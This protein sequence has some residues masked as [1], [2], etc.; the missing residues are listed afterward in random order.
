MPLHAGAASTDITPPLGSSLAGHFNDRRAEEVH[1][2]LRAKALVL[3]SGGTSLAIAILDL[4]CCPREILDRAKEGIAERCGIPPSHVLIACTHTHTGPATTGLL[5][6]EPV[7]GYEAFLIPRIVEAVTRAQREMRP[8]RVGW[9]LGHEPALVFNRR[10]QM[11]DG[12]VRTN[13]G[14]LNPEIVAPVGP[15]DPEVGVLAVETPEGAPIALLASYALHYVGGGTGH[16][17]SADYFGFFAEALQ[18]ARGTPFVAMLANGASGDINNIDVTR[19][20]ERDAFPFEHARRVA[21]VLAAEVLKVWARMRFVEKCPL[22]ATLSPLRCG[23]RQPSPEALAEA[24]ARWARR[25]ADPLQWDRDTIYAGEAVRLAAGPRVV[26]TWVQALRIGDM[27]IA[28]LSGEI[29][30]RLGLDLKAAAPCRPTLLIELANDYS[31]YVPTHAAFTEGGY[32]TWLARSSKLVP[33]TGER[34]VTRARELLGALFGG[35]DRGGE[36]R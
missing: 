17:V 13:P 14:V 4:I 32:E 10:F 36:G 15:T 26:E 27:G 2:P 24:E 31:G 9:G 23:V 19:Q 22:A 25:D 8:A 1:D 16:Q 18:R 12:T 6:V 33:D 21:Q 11:R 20:R 29:F 3:E 28:A 30:C 35:A 34:M 7:P 5:G